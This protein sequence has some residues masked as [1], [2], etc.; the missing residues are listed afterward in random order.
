MKGYKIVLAWLIT[1]VIGSLGLPVW[2]SIVDGGSGF[3]IE[4]TSGILLLGFLCMLVSGVLSAPTLVVLLVRNVLLKKKKYGIRK[5]FRKINVTHII[6]ALLTLFMM[7]GYMLMDSLSLYNN[8]DSNNYG[9][10]PDMTAMVIMPMIWIG[11]LITW[12]MF[13][14]VPAWFLLFRKELREA[15]AEEAGEGSTVLDNLN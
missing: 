7:A 8:L 6:M 12:Y 2:A 5:H 3:R 9:L 14:A 1:V 13:C 11:L 15:R 10:R 4:E